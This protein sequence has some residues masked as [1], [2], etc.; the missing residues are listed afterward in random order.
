MIEFIPSTFTQTPAVPVDLN[1]IPISLW[2]KYHHLK[3][4]WH[5]LEWHAFNFSLEN[6][7]LGKDWTKHPYRKKMLITMFPIPHH[8][9]FINNAYFLM[10]VNFYQEQKSSSVESW[11]L[12]LPHRCLMQIL[13]ILETWRGIN[14]SHKQLR[15]GIYLR[16]YTL[17]LGFYVTVLFFFLLHLESFH[18]R[19][20]SKQQLSRWSKNEIWLIWYKMQLIQTHFEKYP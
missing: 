19:R 10:N 8:E 15:L 7:I 12:S 2:K 17:F 9:L 13:V 6:V 14:N 20:H 4:D 1:K 11:Y 16:H 5:T 18:F 3:S